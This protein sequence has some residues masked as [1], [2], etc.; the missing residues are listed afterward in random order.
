MDVKWQQYEYYETTNYLN[1]NALNLK[2]HV[3]IFF[4]FTLSNC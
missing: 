3:I 2:L 4:Y 1:N